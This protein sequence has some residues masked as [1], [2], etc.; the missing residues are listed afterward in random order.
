MKSMKNDDLLSIDELIVE[1]NERKI[2]LGKGDPYNRLRYYTKIGWLPN[3]VRRANK[4]GEVLG[5]Y[6]TSVIEMI[7]LIN[8]YK[9]EGLSNDEIGKRLSSQKRVMTLQTLVGSENV[10]STLIVVALA[11]VLI[12]A[13]LYQRPPQEYASIESFGAPTQTIPNIILQSGSFY[14]PRGRSE[15]FINR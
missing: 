9:V 5:H 2:D 14:M 8:Q 13:I 3:M 10:R 4:D 6:P 12:G 15:I 11:V 1:L 7:K